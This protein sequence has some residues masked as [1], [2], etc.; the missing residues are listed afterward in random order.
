MPLD[1]QYPA[2]LPNTSRARRQAAQPGSRC[3]LHTGQVVHRDEATGL[4]VAWQAQA[5]YVGLTEKRC[6][7]PHGA[8]AH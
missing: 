5:E 6:Q 2:F 7:K 3:R 8:E 4:A 1:Q